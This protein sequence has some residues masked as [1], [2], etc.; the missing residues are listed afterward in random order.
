MTDNHPAVTGDRLEPTRASPTPTGSLLALRQAI[1]R[2]DEEAREVAALGDYETLARGYAELSALK[3]DLTTLIA[4][5]GD[6]FVDT[7][8][9]HVTGAGKEFHN[10]VH[11][12]EVGTF[13]VVRRPATRRWESDELLHKLVRDN[14]VDRATGDVPDFEALAVVERVVAA[15][16]A[17]APFT[18][19]MGWRVTALRE[20][21]VEIDDYCSTNRPEGFALKFTGGEK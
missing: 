1:A 7:V 16:S 11:I 4:A 6:L 15:I 9:K 14:I 3:R 19:S 5:I 17:A 10:P 8:P 12:E 21:G 20:Q 2:L 13:E 18:P